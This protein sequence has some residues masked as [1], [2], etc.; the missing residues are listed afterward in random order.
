MN[1]TNLNLGDTIS[2]SQAGIQCTGIIVNIDHESKIV[3][4]D[5]Q[6]GDT[7]YPTWAVFDDVIETLQSI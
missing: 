6:I 1:I 5:Q 2:F 4:I 3:D 7:I